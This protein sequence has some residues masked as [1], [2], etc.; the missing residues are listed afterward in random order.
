MATFLQRA[1]R[2]ALYLQEQHVFVLCVRFNDGTYKGDQLDY[3]LMTQNFFY[4]IGELRRYIERM[5][6]TS[7]LVDLM[8]LHNEGKLTRSEYSRMLY[9]CVSKYKAK[10]Q[11]RH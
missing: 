2:E 10:R 4:A 9:A 1:C 5:A 7:E 8:K 3:H 11:D 6:D